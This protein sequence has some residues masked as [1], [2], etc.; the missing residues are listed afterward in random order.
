MR[1]YPNDL[2]IQLNWF[3]LV[4]QYPGLHIVIPKERSPYAGH[5]G[6]SISTPSELYL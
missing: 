2:A 4:V 1:E 5:R 6:Y 3:I